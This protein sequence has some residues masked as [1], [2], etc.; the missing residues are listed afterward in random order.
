MEIRGILLNGKIR[1]CLLLCLAVI[2]TGC[3]SPDKP[4]L[5]TG[6]IKQGPVPG[7]EQLQNEEARVDSR[8]DVQALIQLYDRNFEDTREFAEAKTRAAS[9]YLLLGA[10]YDVSTGDRRKAYR[11]AARAAEAALLQDANFR[12][13]RT[14]GQSIP[15]AGEKV[16]RDQ[17]EALFLWATSVF[18]HFRDVASV[19]ER[20]LFSRRLREA[21][22]A[23][24]F[25]MDSDPLWYGGSLQFSL[26]IYYLSVPEVLG[27]DRDKAAEL[28]NEAVDISEKRLLTRWGRAKYLAVAEGDRESFLHDLTWVIEQNLSSVE[29]PH[30]WN[31]YFQE[32]A[33]R[34][35][36][37]VDLLF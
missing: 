34:L 9:L 6:I 29:G 17:Y 14:S 24:E 7:L 27:G 25:M 36:N 19:P 20:I 30:I 4:A 15:E 31:R 21:A 2:L 1:P 12:E 37:E 3:S 32:D 5:D 33:L 18:Y 22:R 11:N 10:K 13:A 23:I 35:L 8:E 16:S 26:G 28:M